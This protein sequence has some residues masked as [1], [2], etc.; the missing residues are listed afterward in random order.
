MKN[1]DFYLFAI[2]FTITGCLFLKNE[3]KHRHKQHPTERAALIS[4]QEMHQYPPIY[5]VN[6]LYIWSH[7]CHVG[8]VCHVFISGVHQAPTEA[9]LASCSDS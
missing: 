8:K 9:H 5:N 6:R 1:L 7:L 2:T 4:V 3:L